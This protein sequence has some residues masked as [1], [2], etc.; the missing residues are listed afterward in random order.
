MTDHRP[1]LVTGADQHQG[2]AVIRGLGRAGIPVIAAGA[3]GRSIGFYSRH[4]IRRAQYR[5]PFDQP[6]G[7]RE[8]ILRL[9]AE[10]RPAVIIPAVETTLVLLNELRPALDR[11]TAL[12]AP[13][14]HVLELAL[15]KC[16]TLALAERLGVP[17]PRTV[18]GA[19]TDEIVARVAELRPPFAI[20]P[21]GNA[22]HL[23]TAN[24]LGFKSR[25][26]ADRDEL[27]TLL[28]PH[29]GDAP[30]LLVQEYAPGVG[31]CVAAVC[32][33]G[34]PL[35]MFPYERIR[36]YPLSGG[37]SVLRRSIPLDR[38]LAGYVEALLQEIRWH[39]IAM[40]E[41]KYD[42]AARR[43]T[44]MEING[45]FQASTALSLDAGLNLPHLVACLF[46]GRPLP[47]IGRFRIGVTER[48][49]RGDLLALRDGWRARGGAPA[50]T[51][52]P[53]PSK[54]RLLWQCFRDFRPGI[55]YD[56]FKLDDPRPGFV[57]LASLGKL[58]AGWIIDWLIGCG[59]QLCRGL[60]ARA[61]ASSSA[62][63]A[64]R[65]YTSPKIS[66][67]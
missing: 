13:P 65:A 48:W 15:D 25:Y 49:L 62:Q 63:R 22:L 29:T 2:L 59:R 39:G 66:S 19:T 17:V 31:R 37:V 27:R 20:K 52:A 45:R 24:S 54:T 40:V 21:R 23:S 61:S 28:A 57:E 12:A 67:D 33:R 30:A 58:V 1:I 55:R 11:Y 44:L 3:S 18:R 10:S 16:R 43:Y 53:F 34:R 51:R 47:A 46:A 41:F 7:F 38:Q 35:V 60:S 32:D 4:V 6:G 14:Y 5:S 50:C 56:E 26:A 36:E 64:I 8:D 9:V 42:P